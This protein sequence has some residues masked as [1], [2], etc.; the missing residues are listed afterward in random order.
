[1]A[2]AAEF[3]EGQ[4]GSAKE[5]LRQVDEEVQAGKRDTLGRDKERLE[6]EKDVKVAWQHG[7]DT[8]KDAGTTVIG[9]SQTASSTVQEKADQTSSRIQEILNKVCS[10]FQSIFLDGVQ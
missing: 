2:D 7:M 4:A 5:S 9:A 3:I 6:Q 1:M 10:H 8:I